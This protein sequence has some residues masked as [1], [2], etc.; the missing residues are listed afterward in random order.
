MLPHGVH[1]SPQSSRLP[2]LPT[3]RNP[4]GHQP[5]NSNPP[6]SHNP[7]GPP[8]T[9]QNNNNNTTGYNP[10]NPT[11]PHNIPGPHDI[12]N[13]YGHNPSNQ[14]NPHQP[15]LPPHIAAQNTNT[16]SIIS[17][18]SGHNPNDHINLQSML[19]QTMNGQPPTSPIPLMS[20]PGIPTPQQQHTNTGLPAFINQ[21]RGTSPPQYYYDNHDDNISEITQKKYNTNDHILSC[22]IQK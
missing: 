6:T 2:G 11:N 20:I 19:R 21:L 17:P 9:S 8:S 1:T 13:P 4:Y 15:P 5:F 7:Y 16:S 22:F 14:H 12:H 3:S 10:N 18:Q